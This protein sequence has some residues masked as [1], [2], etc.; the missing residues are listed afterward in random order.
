MLDELFLL[1]KQRKIFIFNTGAGAGAGSGLP[2]I[3]YTGAVVGFVEKYRVSTGAG[4][5]VGSLLRVLHTRKTM[6]VKIW[7]TT[8]EQ[9]FL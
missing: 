2:K 3:T 6:I 4:A 7:F 9:N 5:P 8:T 1:E